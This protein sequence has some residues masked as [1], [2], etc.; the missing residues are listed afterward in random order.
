VG[1]N[2]AELLAKRENLREQLKL[3]EKSGDET[4]L[5]KGRIER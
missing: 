4:S 1:E 2:L 5:S 3:K